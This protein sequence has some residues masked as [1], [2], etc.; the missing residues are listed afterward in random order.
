MKKSLTALLL[1]FT[2]HTSAVAQTPSDESLIKFLQLSEMDKAFETGLY[3]SLDFQKQLFEN[4]IAQKQGITPEQVRQIGAIFEKY[5][6]QMAEQILTPPN[7][8][9]VN[10][11]FIDVAKKYYTQAEVDAYN[12]FLSTPIGKSV[13]QK[14]NAMMPEYMSIAERL[15]YE[16]LE[17]GSINYANMEQEIE[18]E[19][20]NL[21][22][23]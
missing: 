1:A 10:Q 18:K 8:Q 14:S 2:L 15:T 9:K 22:K 20:A 12:Q 7:R 21:F 11:A 23:E 4:Q 6:R 19:L 13:T 17:G 5:N 3:A 16:M